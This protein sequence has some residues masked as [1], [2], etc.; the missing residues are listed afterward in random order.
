VLTLRWPPRDARLL[1]L[2]PGE[3]A[4][5][6]EPDDTAAAENWHRRILQ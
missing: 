2:E 3:Q 1:T 5:A 6:R 4:L